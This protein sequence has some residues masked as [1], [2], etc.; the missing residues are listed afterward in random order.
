MLPIQASA[1]H[2]DVPS[3][4][5]QVE[6]LDM[7]NLKGLDPRVY[8]AHTFPGCNGLQVVLS[9]DGD[10]YLHSAQEKRSCSI[11]PFETKVSFDGAMVVEA[12]T[13]AGVSRMVFRD[14]CSVLLYPDNYLVGHIDERG[15]FMAGPSSALR[16]LKT[17]RGVKVYPN[18]ISVML[19]LHGKASP[20]LYTRVLLGAAGAL[21]YTADAT[22]FNGLGNEELVKVCRLSEVNERIEEIPQMLRNALGVAVFDSVHDMHAALLT[23]DR[24]FSNYNTKFGCSDKEVASG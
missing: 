4:K 14:Y 12:L 15:W 21:F 20:G 13:R 24:R 2:C 18:H 23:T 3:L 10:G 6:H 17:H 19:S 22:Y 9:A 8:K 1:S 16:F 11:K 7:S 5:A